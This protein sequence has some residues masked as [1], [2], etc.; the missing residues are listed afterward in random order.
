MSSTQEK[1]DFEKRPEAPARGSSE[2]VLVCVCLGTLQTPAWVH[3]STATEAG[4]HLPHRIFLS[5]RARRCSCHPRGHRCHRSDRYTS[6]GSWGHTVPGDTLQ[7]INKVWK[8]PKISTPRKGW[9]WQGINTNTCSPHVSQVIRVSLGWWDT[10]P[11]LLLVSPKQSVL[12][13]PH[14]FLEK[15]VAWHRGWQ[16]GVGR[17]RVGDGAGR[18]R[19]WAPQTS[20]LSAK[21]RGK[22]AVNNAWHWVYLLYFKCHPLARWPGSCLVTLLAGRARVAGG[23]GALASPWVTLAFATGTKLGTVLPIPA[24]RAG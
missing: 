8:N 14:S 23:T 12:T 20:A 22:V 3:K 13:N 18:D 1:T 21:A 9:R 4:N 6:G 19:G 7:R 10:A 11:W 2:I 15:P 16:G 24:L 5:S 17:I